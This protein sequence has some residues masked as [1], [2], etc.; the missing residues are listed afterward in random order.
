MPCA[1]V[2]FGKNIPN[3]KYEIKMYL[4]GFVKNI[5][6][7][8]FGPTHGN[9][10]WRNQNLYNQELKELYTYPDIV[11]EVRSRRLG[12]IGQT[13]KGEE[14]TTLKNIL[15]EASGPRERPKSRQW[16]YIYIIYINIGYIIL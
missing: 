11:W 3:T 13:L 1:T 16:V 8:T 2:W 7:K 14:E 10:K 6:P 15:K 4:V 5:L 9:G 12:W